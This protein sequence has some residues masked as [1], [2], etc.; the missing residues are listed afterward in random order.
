VIGWL[1]SSD[2]HPSPSAFMIELGMRKCTQKVDISDIGLRSFWQYSPHRS[3]RIAIPL[4]YAAP[5]VSGH[6]SVIKRT[7]DIGS[8]PLVTTK[9][10]TH[11]SSSK[12]TRKFSLVPTAC[13]PHAMIPRSDSLELS[14]LFPF[15]PCSHAA[16]QIAPIYSSLHSSLRRCLYDH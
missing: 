12:T 8:F 3:S 13:L 9:S 6:Y 15:H 2:A 7:I 4:I 11:L 1:S 14:N 10:T 5:T 16:R